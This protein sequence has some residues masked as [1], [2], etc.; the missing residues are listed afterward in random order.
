[1]RLE[2]YWRVPEDFQREVRSNQEQ[3][4]KGKGETL[5]N[6]SLHKNPCGPEDRIIRVSS[7]KMWSRPEARIRKGL[8]SRIEWTGGGIGAAPVV[9]L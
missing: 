2:E 5:S 1:M 4:N 8:E 9:P 3:M 6:P 7:T